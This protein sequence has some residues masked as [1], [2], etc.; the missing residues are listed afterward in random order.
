V[1]VGRRVVLANSGGITSRSSGQLILSVPAADSRSDPYKCP[2]N[3]IELPVLCRP[4]VQ[5]SLSIRSPTSLPTE[6]RS[7]PPTANMTGLPVDSTGNKKPHSFMGISFVAS[8][9]ARSHVQLNSIVPPCSCRSRNETKSGSLLSL[10]LHFSPFD[11]R[12]LAHIC[13]GCLSAL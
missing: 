11:R 5:L 2:N 10:N 8:R 3:S 7:R 13:I 6:G 9:M 12:M 4:C 1:P